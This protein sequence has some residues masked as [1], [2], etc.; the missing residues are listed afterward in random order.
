MSLLDS[1]YQ[2][3]SHPERIAVIGAGYVGIPTA[4]MLAHFGHSVVIAE[5][6][7][8][9]R[10][11]LRAGRSPILEEGL[12]EVLATVVKSG[13]LEVSGDAVQAVAGAKF[14]FLCVATPMDNDGRADLSYIDAV[15]LQIAEALRD[16]AVVVNKSTVPV[17]TMERVRAIINRP[18]VR[19]VSNPE[20]LREGTALG[21]SLKPDRIVVGAEDREAAKSVAELFASTGAPVVVTDATTSELIKYASNAFLATKLSFINTMSRLCD[22][23]GADAD[24]LVRGMG[25]DHRIG[26][27]FLSPGPGWGGSCLPKDTSALVAIAADAGVS[28]E[29]VR[30]AIESNAA[31]QRHIVKQVATMVG[32]TLVSK[33]IAILGLTFKANTGDRRDSPALEVASLLAAAGATLRSFDPTVAVDDAGEDVAKLGVCATP[34]EAV[35]GADA[36]VVLTEWAMFRSLE[37]ARLVPTMTQ[38]CIYDA[39]GVID[40]SQAQAAG[41]TVRRIGRS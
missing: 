10:E 18:G 32:G 12:E 24:D 41:A 7:E 19:V 22:Q 6:D 17:G 35:A 8:F 26:F 20:F 2:S 34:E 33:T 16:D 9:R 29:V 36:V 25:S 14:V 11:S 15:A 13:Q 3:V 40:L 38:P 21:D 30:A 27:P 39:R 1:T 37:W 5:R 28:L 4:V 31:Q 23:L